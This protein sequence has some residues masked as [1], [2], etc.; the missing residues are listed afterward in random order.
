MMLEIYSWKTMHYRQ[1][2]LNFEGFTDRVIVRLADKGKWNITF[3]LPYKKVNV[4]KVKL[5]SKK[6][7]VIGLKSWPKKN[8]LVVSFGQEINIDIKKVYADESF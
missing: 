8:P 3:K 6:G 5:V 4:G 7:G 1:K 2:A